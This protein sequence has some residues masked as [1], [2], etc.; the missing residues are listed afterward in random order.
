VRFQEKESELRR[1]LFS[2]PRE[3]MYHVDESSVLLAYLFFYFWIFLDEKV[4]RNHF[5]HRWYNLRTHDG[6]DGLPLSDTDIEEIFLEGEFTIL[7]LELSDIISFRCILI[8]DPNIVDTKKCNERNE[9]DVHLS[10]GKSKIFACRLSLRKKRD[11]SFFC[12]ENIRIH[13]PN[14]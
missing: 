6:T 8:E 13:N 12:Y 7:Y 1:C 5:L 4:G 14:L 9:D 10:K 3:V 11:M 2:D